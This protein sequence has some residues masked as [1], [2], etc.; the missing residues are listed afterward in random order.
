MSGKSGLQMALDK[1]I[2]SLGDERFNRLIGE[3]EQPVKRSR[4]SSL[5]EASIPAQRST[6]RIITD[7]VLGP[8][9]SAEWKEI[10]LRPD[11]SDNSEARLKDIVND[12]FT[13]LRKRE[14]WLE[15]NN[16]IHSNDTKGEGILG[17]EDDGTPVWRNVLDEQRTRL[18]AIEPEIINTQRSKAAESLEQNYPDWPSVIPKTSEHTFNDYHVCPENLHAARAVD[19]VLDEPAKRWNPLLISG[20]SGTGKSHLLWACG[21]QMARQ[22]PSRHVRILN[23]SEL[24]EERPSGWQRTLTD[25]S[26]LLVDD[27]Q[28]IMNLTDSM[29]MVG[30]VIDYAINVG[31]QIVI[32]CSNSDFSST[33]RNRLTEVLNGT[34]MVTIRRPG[35]ASRMTYLR[36]R[37]AIK[38]MLLD[39]IQLSVIESESSGDWRSLAQS[40]EVVSSA[41]ERGANIEHVADM[42]AVLKG[43]YRTQVH[44][45]LETRGGVE[46]LAGE[47]ISQAMEN[48]EHVP[49]DIELDAEIPLVDLPPD[50]Y[51]TP[52][53][54]PKDSSTAIDNLVDRYLGDELERMKKPVSHAISVNERERHLIDERQSPSADDLIKVK[55]DLTAIDGIIDDAFNQADKRVLNETEVLSSLLDELQSLSEKMATAKARDL[56]RLVDRLYEIEMKLHSVDPDR[57]PVPEMPRSRRSVR[58]AEPEPEPEPEEIIFD[59]AQQGNTS[60]ASLKAL[61]ILTPMEEE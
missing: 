12:R 7:K 2:E 36:E 48:V 53:L 24:D 29:Q 21:L 9:T 40:L 43:N 50:D 41:I 39:D 45:S 59:S 31:V 4:R 27:L 25:T 1:A 51:E 35:L 38:R 56:I 49:L 19:T 5:L 8:K 22:D 3:I 58:R 6:S 32:T 13:E 11:L 34:R 55:G 44:E 10:D 18:M 15:E 57:W 60:V 20:D 17:L 30:E 42:R 54:M 28:S 26:M 16:E 33:E 14:D 37:S 61:T 46:S 23:C 52:D 47:I